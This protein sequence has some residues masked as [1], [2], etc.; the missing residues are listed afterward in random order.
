MVGC[1]YSS[2]KAGHKAGIVHAINYLEEQ[3][4]IEFDE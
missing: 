1:A 3:G 2:F 4:V